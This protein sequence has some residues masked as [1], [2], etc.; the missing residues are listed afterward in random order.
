MK[1]KSLHATALF[2]LKYRIYYLVLDKAASS[3]TIVTS[4]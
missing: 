3:A 4:G 2:R 1:E